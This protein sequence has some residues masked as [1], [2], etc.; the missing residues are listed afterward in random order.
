VD[1][2]LLV[3]LL[4]SVSAA[5]AA[6]GA[7]PLL[8]RARPP[9][10]WLGWAN[11]VAAGTM[12]G[13]SYVLTSVVNESWPLAAGAALGVLFTHWTHAVSGTQSLELNR[14]EGGDPTYGYRIF[15]VG[16]L[17]SGTEGIAIGAAFAIDLRFG[18]FLALA[19]A[20]HNVAEATILVSILR[21][22]GLLLH[23]G[24]G[25]AV[26]ANVSQ[27]LMAVVTFAVLEAAPAIVPWAAGFAMG[28][29]VNLVLVELLPESY[30]ESGRTSIA[31]VSALALATVLLIR[32]V[33]T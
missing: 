21:A 32:G 16:M 20:A 26:A 22:E 6:A 28:G 7:L 24:A 9:R 8:G 15:F 12:L 4:S 31:V 3:L 10:A 19:I 1:A 17:H 33:L 18:A 11:A 27:V 30:R 13:A 2:T 5:A 25:L 23:Q 29:M 14:L